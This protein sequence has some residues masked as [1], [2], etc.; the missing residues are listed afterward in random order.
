MYVQLSDDP[1]VAGAMGFTGQA[2]NFT[3]L[4][5]LAIVEL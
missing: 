3:W 2:S 1:L 5:S 4:N